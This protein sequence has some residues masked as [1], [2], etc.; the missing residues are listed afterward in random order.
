MKF[1]IYKFEE[2]TSTNDVAISLIKKE[3]KQTGCVYAETQTEGRGSSGKKWISKKGNLFM[4][5]FFNISNKIS[6]KKLTSINLSILK[7]IIKNQI[8][9]KTE[10]KLPNDI[11]IYKK[12]VC[13]ILQEIIF[14]NNVKYLIVG[15]GINIISSPDIKNYPTTYLNKY[16]K[17][18]INKIK[19]INE[20]KLIFEKK[21]KDIIL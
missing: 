20:I 5:I 6:L 19:L 4:T 8:K 13:G 11:L 3:K 2:V 18:K 17:Q 10:V 16:S 1:E 12:K 15:I 7:K 14:K 9:I 21:Y